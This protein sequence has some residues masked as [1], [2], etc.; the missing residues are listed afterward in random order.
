MQKDSK[1]MSCDIV[2]VG[3]GVSGLSAAVQAAE[4]GKKV[5]LLESLRRVGGNW[6]VT[7]GMM[8]V[9]SVLSRKQGIKVD[10]KAL[11][12]QEIRFFNYQVNSK[13]WMDM[14]GSSGENIGWLME[15]GVEFE[16]EL[17]PYTAGD[18]NA[19][20]FH[21]WA[22][23]SHPSQRMQAAFE[24]AGGTVL[25]E[26]QGKTLLLDDGKIVG[27][28]AEKSDG[29]PLRIDCKAVISAGGGYA[30]NP[31][32]V[33]AVIGRTD[34]ACRGI[35]ANDGSTI[36]MCIEAGAKNLLALGNQVV[37]LIPRQMKNVNHW[38]T[39]IHSRPGSY[40]F[41]VCVNQD[42][43]RYVDESCTLKLYAFSPSA[44]YTQERTYTIYDEEKLKKL[45]DINQN[46]VFQIMKAA[47][48]EGKE[49][50]VRADT[51]E[52]LGS[53]LGLD[54]KQFAK[55]MK[56]YQ[57]SC[58]AGSDSEYEKTPEFLQRFAPPFYGWENGYQI[59]ATVGGL[60]CNRRMEVVS[61]RNKPIPGLYVAGVD[62]TKLYR[63]YY[64]LAIPG[65]CNANNVYSGRRAARSAVEYIDAQ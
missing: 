43:E 34:Y 2:V 53:R 49:G 25:T 27:V 8:A 48:D 33:S 35:G 57:Q 23:T 63:D 36:Q 50:I 1:K 51:F 30:K 28:I 9:D 56:T 58:E 64:S 22:H 42:A 18:I 10:V 61:I 32:M 38:L 46:G 55:T 5:I 29:E 39:Y 44:A 12:N 47:A 40:P 24:K 62:G 6:D 26:T 21:R 17:E 41:H 14:V 15:Q 65:S 54:S 52:E 11:V 60:D 3:S 7:Y 59:A 4:A 19:P 20:V 37:D 16:P 13:L 45:E 31:E